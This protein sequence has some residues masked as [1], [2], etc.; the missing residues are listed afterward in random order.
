MSFREIWKISVLPSPQSPKHLLSSNSHCLLLLDLK[1]Q[2]LTGSVPCLP[3]YILYMCIRH[4]DY[5]NDDLKVHSLLTSTINGIKR[6]LKVGV[7]G[8]GVVLGSR[9]REA[10]SFPSLAL[11]RPPSSPEGDGQER[12]SSL[13]MEVG[14]FQRKDAQS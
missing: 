3:A 14:S 2:M 13:P 4:A 12:R 10:C 11:P 7:P 6:V 9:C 8:P 5:I 1:P